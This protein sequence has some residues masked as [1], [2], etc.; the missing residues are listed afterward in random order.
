VADDAK[1]SSG[2][3]QPLKDPPPPVELTWSK[4][5]GPADVKFDSQNPKMEILE[6]GQIDQPFRGKATVQAEFGLPGE[7]ILHVVANDYSGDG[8]G[9]EVCCWT[10]ALVKVT[11]T[12]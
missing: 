1:Y 3:N 12:P 4:Y 11:V 2:S 9:G 5:R 7:Y 8:G 10:F 6:G